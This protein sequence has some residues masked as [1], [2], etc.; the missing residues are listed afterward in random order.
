[1]SCLPSLENL[2]VL[3][4]SSRFPKDVFSLLTSADSVDLN[5]KAIICLDVVVQ[6]AT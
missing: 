4:E 2:F 6:S 3:G 5:V 1:W